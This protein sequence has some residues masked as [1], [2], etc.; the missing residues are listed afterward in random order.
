MQIGFLSFEVFSPHDIQ[1]ISVQDSNPAFQYVSKL[2]ASII[3]ALY[4]NGEISIFT[5]VR[6][7]KDLTL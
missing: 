4:D 3:K 1:W 7:L 6:Y 2:A 5:N